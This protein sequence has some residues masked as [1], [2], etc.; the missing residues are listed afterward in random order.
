MRSN[1]LSQLSEVSAAYFIKIPSGYFGSQIQTGV[2]NAGGRQSHFDQHGFV[3][4]GLKV[5]QNLDDVSVNKI[6]VIVL[7][8]F[9]QQHAARERL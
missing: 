8:I 2:L 9:I 3:G 6:E 5:Q 4:I 1:S 7:A